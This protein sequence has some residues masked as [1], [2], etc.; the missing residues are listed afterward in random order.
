VDLTWLDPDKLDDR[1]LAGGVAVIE[2]ARA[3]DCPP[4]LGWTLASYA[5]RVRF[6]WDGEAPLTALLRD[7]HGRVT[8]VLDLLLP[9]WDN[10]HIA[11]LGVTVDPV[12]RRQG[13]GRAL[14]EA[15]V[16]RARAEGRTVIMCESQDPGAGM[17]FLT[18]LGME[19]AYVAVQRRQ[20][21]MAT[22]WDSLDREYAA[23]QAKATGYEL[24]RIP[25]AVPDDM[26][27]GVL[28]MTE[29]IND[30]PTDNLD[31]EDEVFTA[32]RLRSFEATQ[33][34]RNRRLYRI[35][36]RERG[37]GTLAGHTVVGLDT[38]RPWHAWQYDTSVL[39][40]HR[41]HRLGVLL[42][43]AM[44]HWLREQE[45]QLRTIDTT[46]AASNQHMI[47]VNELLGYHITG[48]SAEWQ[49]RL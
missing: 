2:A 26:V 19:R 29:S 41:G 37:T 46:N 18:A 1:D 30:A 15:G 31:V 23:A 22:D 38:E 7:R 24:V 48:H 42:K 17:E 45:P 20:D 13:L 25:G 28:E 44:L 10:A 43:I 33:V 32:E 3:V 40:A 12:V 16:D 27:A 34:A 49:R 11:I 14:F 47:H 6:G 4:R 36:A 21:V 8:G 39:R 9:R 35:V 5:S